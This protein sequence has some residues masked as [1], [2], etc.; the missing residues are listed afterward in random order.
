MSTANANDA[1]P[2]THTNQHP[3]VLGAAARW[4][5][6]LACLFGLGPL[7][8]TLI[9]NLRDIDGGHAVTVLVNG[10]PVQGV[11][12]FAVLFA[13]T[14][15][16][17]LL[18]SR[19]FELSTGLAAAGFTLGWGAWKLGSAEDLLRRAHTTDHLTTQ[20]LE[21]LLVVS[22]IALL[23]GGC[24]LLGKTADTISAPSRTPIPPLA[25]LFGRTFDDAPESNRWKAIPA[26]MLA[27]LV[28]GGLGCWLVALIPAKGQ[29]LCAAIAAGIAAGVATSLTTA[30]L[31]VMPTVLHGTLA[32]LVLAMLGPL[33]AK[34]LHPNAIDATRAAYSNTLAAWA[35][36]TSLDWAAGAL[37]GVPLG[38]GWAGSL[39]ESRLQAASPAAAVRTP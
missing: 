4:V 8:S 16:A 34:F 26:A 5:F 2:H 29:T 19:L 32:L 14:A 6:T 3:S 37:L 17:G 35:Y 25:K 18:G 20:S 39:L 31:R 38:M 28:L 9:G 22:A 15:V 12:A 7:A 27:G 33:T 30:G 24:L 13:A 36:P 1:Q 23:V 21:G 11:I 10:S